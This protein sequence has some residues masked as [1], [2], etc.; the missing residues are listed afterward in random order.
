M[1]MHI[2]DFITLFICKLEKDFF[3]LQPTDKLERK[4]TKP[5]YTVVRQLYVQQQLPACM[6][7]IPYNKECILAQSLLHD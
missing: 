3:Q 2:C 1:H 6:L 7:S 5:V 4:P